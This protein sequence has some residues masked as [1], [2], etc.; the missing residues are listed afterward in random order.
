M[1]SFD[2]ANGPSITVRLAPEYL[3]RQ[4]LE[5]AWSPEASSSTPAFCSSSWYF[6]ISPMSFSGGIT[7]FSLSFVAFTIIMKRMVFSW[8]GSLG[9]RVHRPDESLAL[10][11]RRTGY[12]EID[13]VVD[14]SEDAPNRLNPLG[15][16]QVCPEA[17][18]MLLQSF[19]S[20]VGLDDVGPGLGRNEDHAHV[21]PGLAALVAEGHGDVVVHRFGVPDFIVAVR[22]ELVHQA[23]GR[24]DLEVGDLVPVVAAVRAVHDVAPH[25]ARFHLHA[26]D[27]RGEPVRPPPVADVLGVGPHLPHQLAR[28]VEDSRRR[29][30]AVADQRGALTCR[31][32][33]PA[34]R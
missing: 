33:A 19:E 18:Q 4:P 22:P 6:C 34:P 2:S 20:A 8:V 28:R 31:G 15:L 5:L 25:P 3:T 7:P 13:T 9:L 21:H 32:H 24:D 26:V 29:D 11:L 12:S 16:F 1:S 14:F 30:L 10:T 23:P 27:G 17:R